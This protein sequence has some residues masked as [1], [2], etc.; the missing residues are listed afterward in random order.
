MDLL[1]NVSFSC[2]I[3]N[4]LF[5]IVDNIIRQEI[6]HDPWKYF[7]RDDLFDSIQAK[8]ALI[9]DK[10]DEEVPDKDFQDINQR[11]KPTL[12]QE[13][14]DLGHYLL[15]KIYLFRDLGKLVLMESIYKFHSREK[16]KY[17]KVLDLILAISLMIYP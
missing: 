15:L 1:F 9:Y 11:L 5:R 3:G 12:V 2:G 16:I 4:T 10:E 8:C 17:S 6:H 13:T 7:Y 14:E